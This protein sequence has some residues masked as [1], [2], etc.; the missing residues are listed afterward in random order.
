MEK[1]S[2]KKSWVD[3][4]SPE[5]FWDINRS[6]LNPKIHTRWL[7]E[8]ILERGRWEDWILAAQNIDKNHILQI[9]ETLRIDSKSRNF[10]KRFFYVN[11]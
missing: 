5:L 6:T 4:L 2:D 3:N 8:R 10:L 9:S 1:E 11:N 7:L